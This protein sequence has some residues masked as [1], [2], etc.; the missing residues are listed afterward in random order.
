[1]S[2]RKSIQPVRE[3]KRRYEQK[4]FQARAYL[5]VAVKELRGKIFR[6]RMVAA[7]APEM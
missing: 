3:E 4:L 5:A 6:L 7:F 1:M 2:P